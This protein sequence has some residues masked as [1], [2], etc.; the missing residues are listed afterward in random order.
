MERVVAQ[1]APSI[2]QRAASRSWVVMI[3]R[4]VLLPGIALPGLLGL[5]VVVTAKDVATEISGLILLLI[6]AVLLAALAVVE[7]V[8]CLR[9]DLSR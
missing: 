9:A 2:P 8:D 6:G 5:G 4:L 7:T 3:A 1:V